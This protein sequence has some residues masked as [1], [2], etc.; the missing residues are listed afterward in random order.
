MP[1]GRPDDVLLGG[2]TTRMCPDCGHGFVG[3]RHEGCPGTKKPASSASNL[4]GSTTDPTI[5]PSAASSPNAQTKQR[6]D[7]MP[8]EVQPFAEDPGRKVNQYVLVKQIGK[9]GMGTVWKAWDRKLT[10]WVAVKF[11]L[12]QEDEDVLRFQREA[13]LAARLRHPNIAPIYEVGEAAGGVAGQSARHY[14]AMEFIDGTS[15][16][17]ALELPLRE[18]LEIFQKVAAGVEAAHK[19]GVVHRD[20]K[21]QNVM[22][23]TDKWP[24]VMDFGLAKAL[25]TESNLSVSGAVMGTPAYMPPEQA[26][27]HLD[28]IDAQSDVYSLGATMYAVVCKKQPFTGQSP[29][30]VLMKVCKDEPPKPRSLIADLPEPVE[31]MILK[32][33][34]KEKADRYASA[35]ALADDIKRFLSE[36]EVGA[37]GPSSIRTAARRA[38]GNPWPLVAGAAVLI[39]A[40]AG[41]FVMLRKPPSAP[42]PTA[43]PVAVVPAP[44]PPPPPGPAA[45]DPEELK[46]REKEDREQK[47]INE[48]LGIRQKVNFDF[49]APGDAALGPKAV[50]LLGKL[51][52]DAS[53]RDVADETEWLMNQARTVLRQAQS[54]GTDRAQALK[55]VGWCDVMGPALKGS[56]KLASASGMVEQSRTIAAKIASFRGSV[57]LKLFVGPFAEVVRVSREGTNLTLAAKATP[58]VVPNVE[59]GDFEVELSHPQHGKK[60]EKI[61]ASKLKDGKTYVL[62]GRLQDAQLRLTE[63]P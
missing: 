16:A 40:V 4:M 55:V 56:P 51:D 33:M 19:G 27:G 17:S 47:W 35:G 36:G 22:L 14:L 54:L 52:A 20:L 21:P 49:W 32:A 44:P 30:E 61:P 24:Y 28:Q 63:Q 8:A 2:D 11:L 53:V 12:A 42:P 15:M 13:K 5:I 37:Q 3:E 25:Q 58:L 29:M 34:S 10:R 43:P 31:R 45:P 57:T 39:A 41:G 6:L 18:K 48:W 23:T 59:I 60:V 7:D 46:R 50:E 1:E 62:S 26:Q 9:G 38:K